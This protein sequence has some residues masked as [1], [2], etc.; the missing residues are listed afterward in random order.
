MINDRY[1][2]LVHEGQAVLREKASRFIGIAFPMQDEVAFKLRL[3]GLEKEHHGA[4]HFCFGWVLGDGAERQR[5]NDA[6]EPNATA[7]KPILNRI[8][9]MDLT[10]CGV[11][12]VRYFGGTLLGT[13]GL[14]KAYGS[15]A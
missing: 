6:G 14:I 5:A 8:R 9:S 15:A 4:R 11:V 13:A 10:Y 1:R 12:V 7:G 2:T 3:L